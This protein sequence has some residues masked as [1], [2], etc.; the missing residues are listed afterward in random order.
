MCDLQIADVAVSHKHARI[1]CVYG[2]WTIEDMESRNGTR[3]NHR[4]IKTTVLH[5]GDKIQIG[6]VELMFRL[7][8]VKAKDRPGTADPA[9]RDVQ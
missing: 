1:G 6:S 9:E 8:G 7:K 4:S 2:R 5:D 3:V